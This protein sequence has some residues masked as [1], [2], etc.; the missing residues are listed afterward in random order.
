[1]DLTILIERLENS[2]KENV[3]LIEKKLKEASF[4][5]ELSPTLLTIQEIDRLVG[6]KNNQIV[7]FNQ[8]IDNRTQAI[9]DIKT[10][11][12]QLL[13]KK[14]D[15]E[16][17]AFNQ[18]STQRQQK[19]AEAKV[20]ADGVQ[21][22]IDNQNTIILTNQ[23]QTKNIDTAVNRINDRLESFGLEGFKIQKIEAMQEKNAHFY[24]I[25]HNEQEATD[26]AFKKLSEGEKTLVSFLYFVEMCLG[27][28]D[29]DKDGHAANRIIVI[30]DP[31]SSLSF[32]LVF[33]VATLIKDLFL[34]PDTEYKQILILTH[35]L[36]F[37]HELKYGCR[38][39]GEQI[40]HYR[41]TKYRHT[42]I[43]ELKMQD[44]KNNYQC[45]WQVIK[46]VKEGK[47]S[48]VMLPNA[49]RNILEH[50]FSFIRKRDAFTKVMKDMA[51]N[52]NDH[53]LKAF[54]RYVNKTSHSD[55]INLTDMQEID[56]VK[57]IQYF[58]SVF[59]KTG[60]IEHYLEMMDEPV[61]ANANLAVANQ[62]G[63]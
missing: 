39:K 36:Y 45:Y 50:Y 59:D 22:K 9:A 60:F 62:T 29:A 18:G 55:A 56:P 13:R 7:I 3:A 27:T 8:K 57:F 10:K 44:I 51:A 49:M 34:T 25:A 47:L 24:K 63:T 1:M 14:F 37:L 40:M 20:N 12:W 58:K 53:T 43:A 38:V 32:N 2:L 35:H 54:D 6:D 28:D 33:D 31:I 42:R 30:D 48:S 26:N 5:V 52:S 15:A 46:D 4:P 21:E 23:A 41:V 11:F 16:I 61:P 17:A 19:I